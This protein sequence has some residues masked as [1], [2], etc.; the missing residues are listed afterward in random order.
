MFPKFPNHYLFLNSGIKSISE[1]VNEI[2]PINPKPLKNYFP[3]LMDFYEESGDPTAQTYFAMFLQKVC[4]K[5]A[6]VCIQL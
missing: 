4:K 5:Q 6:E 1:A 2:Y 3:Q